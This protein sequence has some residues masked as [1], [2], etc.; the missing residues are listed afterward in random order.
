MSPIHGNTVRYEYYHRFSG[1]QDF[2]ALEIM[3]VMQQMVYGCWL[4]SIRVE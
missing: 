2:E 4:N 3:M 1:P